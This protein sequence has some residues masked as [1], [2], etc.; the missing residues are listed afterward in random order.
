M[1]LN[2]NHQNNR[3]ESERKQPRE[4]GREKRRTP[5]KAGKTAAIAVCVVLVLAFAAVAG[6][7][8]WEKPVDRAGGGLVDPT[9]ESVPPKA[10]EAPDAEPSVEPTQDPNEGAPA[11]L[12]EN[13]YTFLVVGLDQVSNS[14]D[15]I[16]VGRIDTETHKIDVVSIPRDTMVNVSWGTKRVNTYYSSDLVSG[17]NGIDGLMKGIRD[18]V[19]FDIDC[20]AVVDL[21]AFVELVDAIGGVDYDVP[22]D[23][24]YYDPSQGLNISIPAGMQHLDGETAVKVVRFRSGYPTADIGRIGTQQDF[25]MSVASQMLTLGNI[26]NLP[27]FIDIF[28][29]YVTTNLSA[30]NISF[31]A[32]QF[33]MCKSEDIGFHT[34]PGNGGDSVKGNSYYSLYV[35][36]WL[37]MVNECLNPYDQP[38]TTANVNILTHSYSS[39]F[40]STTGVIAGGADSFAANPS[41]SASTSSDSGGEDSAG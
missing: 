23:M 10:S 9:A 16:M 13:M 19:G 38:V 37:E 12:N 4:P 24:Y 25:L 3:S 8:A 7:L 27:T 20:Y 21:E 40:Y 26:P 14:T 17:G 41:W 35:D 2:G 36:E 33:L 34:A 39:G 31:F 18:L 11:S 30:A 28:E 29:K 32:R 22:I 5:G 1:K 6:Y 15:T